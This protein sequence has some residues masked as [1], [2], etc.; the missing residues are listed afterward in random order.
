MKIRDLHIPIR[1][2]GLSEGVHEFELAA[3]PGEIGLPAEFVAAI[4]LQITLDKTHSQLV[5]KA[6]AET[7]AV[8]PCDRCLDPVTVPVE[9][10][11]VLFFAQDPD[12]ARV[13]DEEDIRLLDPHQPVIDIGDDVRDYLLLAVPMRRICGEKADG[14][15]ACR[16]AIVDTI[17]AEA[18][19]SIDPRWEQ[20]KNIR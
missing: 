14:S 8:F 4:R 18:D 12:S 7:T 2:S 16:N 3:N 6:K 19:D 11:F 17:P 1:V 13:M 9:R 20:L 5:L 10:A 15:P